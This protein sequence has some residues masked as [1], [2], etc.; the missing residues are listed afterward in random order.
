MSRKN[1]YIAKSNLVYYPPY[2][3]QI[4]MLH[5]FEADVEVWLGF[6][7]NT[8]KVLLAEEGIPFA[9]LVD[10]RGLASGKLDVFLNW[11][12]F[13][14]ALKARLASSNPAS[15]ILWFGTAESAKPMAGALGGWK[16]VVSALELYDDIPTKKRLLG[17]L[18]RDAVTMTVHE[19]SR[20]YIMQRWWNPPRVPHVFQNKP[21]GV[22]LTR[23]LTLACDE[24]LH[25][26]EDV[27]V[28]CAKKQNVKVSKYF[29]VL[30]RAGIGMTVAEAITRSTP[31]GMRESSA[32]VEASEGAERFVVAA[33]FC[34]LMATNI[35]T[36][37]PRLDI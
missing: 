6:S 3:S 11:S 36:G 14:R 25:N 4:H 29:L 18:A 31:V 27:I 15:T 10:P 12:G 19:I 35:H 1:I 21:N 13:R 22:E 5:D 17:S 2:M 23:N 9:E 28:F 24:T 20:A 34:N 33:V 8:A 30:P 37:V 26:V 32:Y 16:Y 7:K